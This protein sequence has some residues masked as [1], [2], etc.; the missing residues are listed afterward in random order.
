MINPPAAATSDVEANA[1][2]ART[3]PVIGWKTSPSRPLA[4]LTRLPPMKWPY[5][6]MALLP[7]RRGALRGMRYH[8]DTGSGNS[9][10][11]A[12]WA[13]PQ[14]IQRKI[15]LAPDIGSIRTWAEPHP[16]MAERERAPPH[17][18]ILGPTIKTTKR[19]F[20]SRPRGGWEE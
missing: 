17:C 19:K 9:V 10:G 12:T 6:I 7:T 8:A 2:L 14:R 16:S 15:R 3:S 11:P 5:S 13:I 4:P 20:P 1:T 18:D